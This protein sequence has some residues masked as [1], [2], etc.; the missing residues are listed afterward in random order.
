MKVIQNEI[1]I[2]D[3]N[4]DLFKEHLLIK[5]SPDIIIRTSN[6]IRLS[7]FMIF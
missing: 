6:E 5:E 4:L 7:D 2:N 3:I 1:Q